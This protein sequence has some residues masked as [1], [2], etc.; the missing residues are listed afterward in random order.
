[1]HR[2]AYDRQRAGRLVPL[3][4]SISHEIRERSREIQG[5][6]LRLA[7]LDADSAERDAGELQ[8]QLAVHRRE[9]RFAKKEL[10][11]LGCSIDESAPFRILIPGQDGELSHG[12]AWQPGDEDA[13][14]QVA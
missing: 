2:N 11:R 8:A 7:E 9:L 10:D 5:L 6:E 14:S 4:R 12:Y 3:L 1:M 13:L